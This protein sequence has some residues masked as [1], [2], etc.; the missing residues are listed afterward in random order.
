MLEPRQRG[1]SSNWVSVLQGRQKNWSI[2]SVLTDSPI[3]L[4][5]AACTWGGTVMGTVRAV[6]SSVGISVTQIFSVSKRWPRFWQMQ[7]EPGPSAHHSHGHKL[8]DRRDTR[9]QKSGVCPPW[10]T[11]SVH[12]HDSRSSAYWIQ[13]CLWKKIFPFKGQALAFCKEPRDT[14]DCYR[15]YINKVWWIDG[16]IGW[17]I[18]AQAA[19]TRA[20][21]SDVTIFFCYFLLR[22]FQR[23][24]PWKRR[25]FKLGCCF[26]WEPRWEQKSS[27]SLGAENRRVLCSNP[28]ADKISKTFR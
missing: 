26:S 3:P 16:L 25:M 15:R 21:V 13:Y 17:L 22:R 10:W 12:S 14:L 27:I 6:G 24:W 18:D 28:G 2:C 20:N 19:W 4:N 11:N 7:L 5:Q 9:I 23:L 1:L 8:R